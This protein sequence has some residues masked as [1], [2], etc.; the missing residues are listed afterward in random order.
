MLIGGTLDTAVPIDPETIRAFELISSRHLYRADIVG[1]THSHFANICDIAD[2][3]IA[4]GFTPDRW[5]GTVAEPLIPYYEE[6]C[7][8]EAFP[9]EEVQRI[10]ALYTVAFFRRHLYLD[11]RYERFLKERY[12]EANEPD[13]IYFDASR[14]QCGNGFEMALIL[15]P[16]IWLGRRTRRIARR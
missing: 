2:V 6:A 14:W 10:Q 4:G 11:L 12:A 13:V 7:V 1:A 9:A 5:P 3:L 15:P 16:L 8:P